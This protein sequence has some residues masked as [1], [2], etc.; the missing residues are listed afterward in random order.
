MV[1]ETVHLT[2]LVGDGTLDLYTNG[3]P[4][5]S[6]TINSP[7]DQAGQSGSWIGYS[8]YGDP[9]IDG[10]VDEYRIYLGRLSPEE[11][12][13]SDALGPNQT[14]STSATMTASAGGGNVV[15]T[16]PLANAGFAVETA[17]S[18]S[19]PWTTLTNAPT[20]TGGQ[21]QLTLPAPGGPQ[22][23]QLIR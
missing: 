6:T 12:A 15:L 7:A 10:S 21:W 20:L 9:G 17:S 19:G 22:F 13:A 14:L 23:Y 8:P 11:I 2:C 3:V 5:L 1:N 18:V 16:W 4:Y